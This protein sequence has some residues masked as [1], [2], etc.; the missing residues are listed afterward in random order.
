ME[1]V[2]APVQILCRQCSAPL[3]VE[4]GTQFVICEYCGTTNHVD[5]GRTVF[6]YAVNTT[7]RENE[8]ESSLRRW[9]AGNDTVK[10]LDRVARIVSQQFQHFPMWLVRVDRAG[11]ETIYLEPAAALSVSEIKQVTIPAADLEPY[12][13]SMDPDSVE[14]TVPYKAMLG[15]LEGEHRIREA[16]ISELSLV[17]VPIYLFKYAYKDRQ[18]TAVV[19]GAAGRVFANIFPSK[20]ETPYRAIGVA[21]FVAYFIASFIPSGG[22]LLAE[23]TG[24]GIGIGIYIIA[25]IVLAIPLFIVA[26]TISAKI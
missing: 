25:V 20:W 22:F 6:H 7:V 24:L 12:D 8:A 2:P 14:A 5:K 18:Y 23:G 16:E 3:P 9:M 13:Q 19:D 1:S 26:A 15:W 10:G 17:H 21:A 11:T 4:Q